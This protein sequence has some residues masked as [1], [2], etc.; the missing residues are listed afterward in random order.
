MENILYCPVG[1]FN[2]FS[3]YVTR[4]IISIQLFFFCIDMYFHLALFLFETQLSFQ[5]KFE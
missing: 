4:I 2:Y 1:F 5:L 3:R